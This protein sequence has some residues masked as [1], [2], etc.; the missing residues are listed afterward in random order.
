MKLEIGKVFK[1][2]F[3][4]P[5]VFYIERPREIEDPFKKMALGYKLS[6]TV[7]TPLKKI[8]RRLLR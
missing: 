8:K 7:L 2:G 1:K 4:Y 6:A 3:K 5:E